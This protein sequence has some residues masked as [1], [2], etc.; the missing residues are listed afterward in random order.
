MSESAGFEAEE[1][2]LRA[3][4]ERLLDET[5]DRGEPLHVTADDLAVDVPIRFGEDAPRARWRFDGEV[6]VTVDGVRG[7]L[8]EWFDIHG[9]EPPETDPED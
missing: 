5:V 3:T 6:T 8:R 1:D 4:V 7:P 2:G 9:V